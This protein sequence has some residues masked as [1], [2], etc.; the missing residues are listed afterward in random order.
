[1]LPRNPYSEPSLLSCSGL[2]LSIRFGSKARPAARDSDFKHRVFGVKTRNRETPPTA[3]IVGSWQKTSSA[4]LRT[5]DA[6]FPL[7]A[8][9]QKSDHLGASLLL[10]QGKGAPSPAPH[11]RKR[12]FAHTR[13]ACAAVQILCWNFC[14]LTNYKAFTL[15]YLRLAKFCE[16]SPLSNEPP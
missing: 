7:S 3:P 16:P 12:R 8:R 4:S 15:I 10:M 1:M 13:K 6:E 2:H 9:K 14:G 5:A 11:L